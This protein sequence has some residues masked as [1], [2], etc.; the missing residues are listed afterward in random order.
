MPI[1]IEKNVLDFV[2]CGSRPTS[3][4]DSGDGRDGTPNK[5]ALGCEELAWEDVDGDE[6]AGG[7]CVGCGS[8]C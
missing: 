4:T 7:A 8:D 1:L 6:E 2:E 3:R 5:C